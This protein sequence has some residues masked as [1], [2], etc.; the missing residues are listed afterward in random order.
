MAFCINCG[1][2]LVADAKFCGHCGTPHIDIKNNGRKQE[3][4]GKVI[5]CPSCGAEVSSF[6]AICSSC[7]HEI[8]SQQVSLSLSKLIH[9]LDEIERAISMEPLP[10]DKGWKTWSNKGR[11]LWLLINLVTFFVPI[12]L[13]YTFP[14]IKRMFVKKDIKKLTTLEKRKAAIIE[15]HVFP[16]E[17]EA[18]VE[19]MLFV[20]SKVDFLSAEKSDEKNVYWMRLW[21]EKAEQIYKKADILLP[22]DT[23]I[24]EARADIFKQGEECNKRIKRQGCIASALLSMLCIL[25]FLIHPF[26]EVVRYEIKYQVGSIWYQF[27]EASK[28][29]Y[30]DEEYV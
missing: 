8:N 12:A 22:N 25:C 28:T 26:F 19:G 20:K 4:A 24:M 16:N 17:R 13:K 21:Q 5:K 9:N 15:N 6:T 29:K 27:T 23:I 7:G 3:W 14:A 11:V 18:L 10:T 1:K 2:E 30:F